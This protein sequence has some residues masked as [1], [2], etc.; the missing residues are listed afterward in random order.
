MSSSM[1][2]HLQ[3]DAEEVLDGTVRSVRKLAEDLTENAEA[4]AAQAGK[5]AR[6]AVDI[7]KAHPR[8]ATIGVIGVFAGLLAIAGLRRSR[9][10]QN[11]RCD[12]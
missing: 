1:T 8:V 10:S 2:K 11:C 3:R 12:R 5:A 4:A 9:T 7:A 6:S